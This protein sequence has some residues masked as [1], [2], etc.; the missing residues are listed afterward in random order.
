MLV[1]VPPPGIIGAI[2]KCMDYAEGLGNAPFLWN[3]GLEFWCEFE[4]NCITVKSI[5]RTPAE[6]S[7]LNIEGLIPDYCPTMAGVPVKF[8]E[9]AAPR[10]A[11][12]LGEYGVQLARIALT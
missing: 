3:C 11:I 4:N 5:T 10:E 12:L 6:I 9:D 1:S 8:G 7:V 2:R